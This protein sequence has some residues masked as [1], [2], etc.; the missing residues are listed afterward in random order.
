M[1][2]G[3]LVA[4]FVVLLAVIVLVA[5]LVAS[6]SKDLDLD[7]AGSN[8]SAD[9]AGDQGGATAVLPP[10]NTSSITGLGSNATVYFI[11]VGQGDAEL[12][13]TSDGRNILIDAGPVSAASALVSFLMSH[14][15]STLDAFVLTHPDADHIGGGAD[16]LE[17]CTVLSVYQSGY[18]A[19]TKTYTTFE[20]A[21]SEEGCPA[22]NDTQLNPGDRLDINSTVTFE[23]MAINAQSNNPND[24]S[25]I[26]K[27]TD[28]TVDFLFVGDSS[29]SVEGQMDIAF[30][31][32]MDI[33]ILKVGHHGSSTSTSVSFLSQTTPAIAVIEVGAGNTFN[34]PTNQTLDRLSAAGAEVYRTDLNGTITITTDGTTWMVSC[35]R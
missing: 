29:S 23:I 25:L 10:S 18:L 11:D 33:E 26:I 35:E 31:S 27:M 17:A 13:K 32:A 3:K 30:G 6:F 2:K 15:A 5:L 8:G 28:G 12:I 9:Q 22:Y 21:V 34:H 14:N 19:E 7:T 20:A 4:T 24:A 1:G 16:V